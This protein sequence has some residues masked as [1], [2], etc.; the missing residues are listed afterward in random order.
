MV[1]GADVPAKQCQRRIAVPASQV[2]QDLV[3]GPILLDDIK[4]MMDR[5]LQTLSRAIEWRS[6]LDL[7]VPRRLLGLHFVL[8]NDPETAI[9][10][11]Q[12][13]LVSGLAWQRLWAF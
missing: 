5:N 11:C 4:N 13:I 7:P 9:E 2:A 6:R 12:H 1:V 8:P 3:V 10:Q